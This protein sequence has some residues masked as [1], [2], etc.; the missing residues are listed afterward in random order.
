MY[1]STCLVY[2][3]LHELYMIFLG[4]AWGEEWVDMLQ[5]SR[6]S[7]AT[8]AHTERDSSSYILEDGKEDESENGK[9]YCI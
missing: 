5:I 3:L 1:L 7:Q 2:L 9:Q 4:S 6:F 8:L